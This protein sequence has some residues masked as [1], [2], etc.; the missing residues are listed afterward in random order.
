MD[1]HEAFSNLVINEELER[2]FN[3]ISVEKVVVSKARGEITVI[4]KGLSPLKRSHIVSMQSVLKGQIFTS[5]EQSVI[6][7]E[8][9][10]LSDYS[11]RNIFEKNKSSILEELNEQGRIY[12][13]ILNKSKIDFDD[14]AIY[15]EN[16][17]NFIIREKLKEI[18]EWLKLI[19]VKRYNK[20]VSIHLSLKLITSLC[21]KIRVRKGLVRLQVLRRSQSLLIRL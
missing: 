18:S 10:D 15:I 21:Q 3:E 9:Y 2:A 14:T 12:Y 1:F 7:E 13:N 5:R 16:E 20:E 8:R 17:D 6:I 11:T 19:F 4:I